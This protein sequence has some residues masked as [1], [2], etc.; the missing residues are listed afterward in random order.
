[1]IISKLLHHYTQ[2]LISFQ[3]FRFLLLEDNEILIYSVFLTVLGGGFIL[4]YWYCI[5]IFILLFFYTMCLR[6]PVP[7]ILLMLIN[8]YSKL[9]F[10]T[11]FRWFLFVAWLLAFLDFLYLLDLPCISR[12]ESADSCFWPLI[13]LTFVCLDNPDIALVLHFTFFRQLN[14]IATGSGELKLLVKVLISVMIFVSNVPALCPRFS[15]S[16]NLPCKI[17]YESQYLDDHLWS[18]TSKCYN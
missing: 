1:M 12:T 15:F 4:S 3:Y 5:S 14:K 7:G 11:F 8:L 9:T 6:V 17:F 18:S 16:Q 2:N 13:W 10:L